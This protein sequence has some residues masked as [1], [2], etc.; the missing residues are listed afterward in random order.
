MILDDLSNS[1][2]SVIDAIELISGC[3]PIFVKGSILNQEV[4]RNIFLSQKIDTVIHFAGLKS[5][6]ESETNPLKYYEVNVSGSV[7]LLKEMERAKVSRLVFSSSATVY[8]GNA[9]TKYDEGMDLIPI[10]VYGHTKLTIEKIC[11]Q[12][13]AANYG[14][15][16]INLRYFNPVGAHESGL[17]GED[18]RGVPNNLMPYIAQV[19]LGDLDML[20][21]YGDDYPTPDGTCLRDY[22]H[23]K[24][25][26]L[27]HLSAIQK[28]EKHMAS[29]AINLGTGTPHSVFEM[30]E[31]FEKV[32]GI[33]IP[34]KVVGRRKG[35]LAEYYADPTLAS[36][37]LN[38]KANH[39]IKK[40]CEDVW[41]RLL[42]LKGSA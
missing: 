20:S 14:F 42:Y 3:R 17:I 6:S 33:K 28:L 9:A 29:I 27:G 19:A 32:S 31:C 7:Q 21:V 1:K 30:I 8:G 37:F 5:V 16:V 13:A 2:Q 26:A 15:S 41:N 36:E 12:F 24:D 39:D 40:M 22:I 34:Y 35:D 11:M 18:P 38:W 23:V 25:L 10:N 4:L